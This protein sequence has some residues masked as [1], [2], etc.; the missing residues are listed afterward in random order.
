[1]LGTHFYHEI[2]RKTIIG[3]GTLFNNIEL[4]RTDSAGNIVQTIKVPLAYG[5][6]EKFLARLETEPRLEGRAEVGIQ[7]PRISFEMKGVQYDST[8]KMSPINICTKEKSGDVKGVYK[9][10]APV[11]YNVDFE[12]NIISKNNDESVQ[13]LSLIHI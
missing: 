11:P 4:R 9:Q 2:I 1:M 8:R 6:R 12:L 10:Y 5:P 7:L 13:I 3:F